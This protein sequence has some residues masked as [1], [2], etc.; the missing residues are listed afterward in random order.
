VHKQPYMC[1][2][3]RVRPGNWDIRYALEMT[4]TPGDQWVASVD[5]AAGGVYE[6]KY[7]IINYETKEALEW[8]NGS[9]AV[10]AII[11]DDTEVEVFDN[12]CVHGWGVGADVGEGA[13]ECG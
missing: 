11:A 1:A 7:V 4:Y 9:N 3:A 2:C 8:Q 6:Y 5:L 12:W 13:C 10:L